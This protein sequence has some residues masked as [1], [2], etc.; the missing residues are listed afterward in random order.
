MPMPEASRTKTAID[1]KR[2]RKRGALTGAKGSG[3]AGM[4]GAAT[5]GPVGDL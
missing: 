3:A 1:Q 4:R 5:E 2:G